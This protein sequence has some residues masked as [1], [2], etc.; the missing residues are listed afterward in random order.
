MIDVSLDAFVNDAESHV[1][2]ASNGE[3][4]VVHRDGEPLAQLCPVGRALLTSEQLLR[5]WRHLPTVDLVG[6]RETSRTILDDSL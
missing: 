2:R 6:L 4:I 5:A 1:E 3:T